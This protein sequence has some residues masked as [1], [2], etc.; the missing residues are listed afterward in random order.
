MET[1]APDEKGP[2]GLDDDDDD[3]PGDGSGGGDE[4]A[5]WSTGGG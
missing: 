2:K 5:S 3:D 4:D 1:N